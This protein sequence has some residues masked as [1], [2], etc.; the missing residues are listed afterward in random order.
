[1]LVSFALYSVVA[2]YEGRPVHLPPP[3]YTRQ[4]ILRSRFTL[5]SYLV[6]AY[7]YYTQYLSFC[8]YSDIEY[9]TI[10][11]SKKF[12]IEAVPSGLSYTN[13]KY[14]GRFRLYTG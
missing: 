1:M 6:I 4:L 13:Q 2:G 5:S 10:K 9:V 12:S 7:H 3:L 11:F 8:Q 14:S